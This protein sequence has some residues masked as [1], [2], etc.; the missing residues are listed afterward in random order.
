MAAAERPPS[1]FETVNLH[2]E[3]AAALTN[4]PRGLLDQIKATGLQV[5][6]GLFPHFVRRSV[7]HRSRLH[8]TLKQGP[9]RSLPSQLRMAY[10]LSNDLLMISDLGDRPRETFTEAYVTAVAPEALAQWCVDFIAGRQD[11]EGMRAKIAA[12]KEEC[13]MDRLN[14]EAITASFAH[15]S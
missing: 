7:M 8:L 13:R 4:Y 6:Y 15:C 11:V 12:F 9:D 3:R 2:F 5:V 10:C 14:A 1:F